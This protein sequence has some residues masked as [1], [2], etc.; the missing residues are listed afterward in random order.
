[1]LTG[2]RRVGDTLDSA[3]ALTAPSLL[4]NS[5]RGLP[6]GNFASRALNL[7]RTPP[8]CPRTCL[9]VELEWCGQARAALYPS[10]AVLAQKFLMKVEDL[11]RMKRAGAAAAAA[12]A[13]PAT[14]GAGPFPAGAPPGG[15]HPY[16]HP[17]AAAAAAAGGVPRP[18]GAAAV[19]ACAGAPGAPRPAAAMYQGSRY[20]GMGGHAAGAVTATLPTPAGIPM[21]YYVA[22]AP[23]AAAVAPAADAGRV[24]PPHLPVGSGSA[25]VGSAAGGGAGALTASGFRTG[26]SAVQAA[27]PLAHAEAQ[28]TSP[29]GH[30]T[31]PRAHAS[32]P[33]AH[34]TSPRGHPTSPRA[35]ATS[36][37][38]HAPSPRA[39]SDTGVSHGQAA[40][41]LPASC[42][43]I[44]PPV[45]SH[46]PAPSADVT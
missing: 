40:S 36:P 3:G 24:A 14:A 39:G 46:A 34:A 10:G 25:A 30:P 4:Q 32:S 41:Q 8:L 20:G 16:P 42:A 31:S 19:G 11:L 22:A 12:A 45:A 33:P 7:A 1:M 28:P 13:A 15:P 23:T 38:A 18:H 44:K 21:G 6:S 29:R 2:K 35:H 37:P 17:A 9:Q 5:L 26:D 27:A 43:A